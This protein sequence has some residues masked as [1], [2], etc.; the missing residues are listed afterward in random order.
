MTALVTGVGA[1]PGVS[2]FKALR[3]S[4][5][6]PRIVATDA[7]P[8]SVGLFRADV[9]CVLPRVTTDESGYLAALSALCLEER[10]ELVCFGSEIEMRRVAPHRCELEARTGARLVVNEAALVERFMDKWGMF[11]ALRA[12]GLPVPDTALG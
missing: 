4:S 12:K 1:P 10:V 8:V 7:E 2:I 5:L 3:Q 6:R 11:T 9:G